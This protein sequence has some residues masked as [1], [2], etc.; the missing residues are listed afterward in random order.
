[1]FSV[2][3]FHPLNNTERS[4]KKRMPTIINSGGPQNVRIM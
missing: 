3:I 2:P 4:S 1:M